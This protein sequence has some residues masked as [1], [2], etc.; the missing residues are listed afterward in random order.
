V[1][2]TPEALTSAPPFQGLF[3]IDPKLLET[4]TASMMK[5]G[6]DESEPIITWNCIVVDG[7]TRLEAAKKANLPTVFVAEKDFDSEDAAL[8]YAI[9]R[10]RDRRNLTDA[11]ILRLVAELDK[12]KKSGERTDLAP[13]EAR[14]TPGKS[15]VQTA[16]MIGTSKTKVEKARTVMDKA[17][18]EVKEAIKKGEKS[19]HKAYQET[20]KEPEPVTLDAGSIFIVSISK[21]ILAD[22]KEDAIEQFLLLLN[23]LSDIQLHKACKVTT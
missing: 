5:R 15:A 21:E 9:S 3:P 7:H 14:L 11:D 16:E 6:Y 1:R 17:T 12:R 20:V 13:S 18:D 22:N 4:I 8:A 10:Q 2:I 23:N 19:I